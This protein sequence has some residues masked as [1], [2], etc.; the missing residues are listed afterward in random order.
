MDK[1]PLK[2]IQKFYGTGKEISAKES[3]VTNE[4]SE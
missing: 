1:Y 4:T 2:E 3:K